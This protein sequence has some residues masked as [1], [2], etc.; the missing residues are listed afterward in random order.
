MPASPPRRVVITG[1]GLVSP[2]G[3]DPE[4]LWDAFLSQRSGVA[5]M[6]R[7]ATDYLPT[8]YGAEAWDFS[9]HIDDFGPLESPQKRTIRKGLKVMC[10]EVQMGVAAAQKAIAASSLLADCDP[11]R[12]G[13]MFGADY[14]VTM[15]DEFVEGVR[16]CLD[17][18][19]QFDFSRWAE[20]GLPRITPLWLL[21]YLPNMPASHVAIYNDLRG[22]NNSIT[23]REAS[24]NL[25]CSEAFTTI[26]RGAADAMVVG[27]TGSR[28]NPLRTVHVMIQGELATNGE[29]PAKLCRPFDL[30]RTG[31]VVG[32][33]AGAIVVEEL[34]HAQARGA[35]VLGEIVG[36][37]SSTVANR[38]SVAD[39]GKAI[40]NVLQQS[41]RTASLTPD[42]VGHINAHGLGTRAC[43]AA[44]AQAIHRLFG[45]RRVPVMAP[46]SY[47]G[48][49][50][51]GSGM[52]EL[53]AS[54][55]A[56][57]RSALFP[58][59]N[60]ETP[61]P[62]CPIQASRADDPPGD[63]FLNVNVSPQ[64]QASALAVGRFSE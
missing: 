45:D 11:D 52:I 64:G 50:G 15:P 61:D 54:L 25:A 36:Y 37:G 42:K 17:D 5:K 1:V 18:Q 23:L 28:V 24:A 47:F 8:P 2:L 62:D 7:V 10:R 21:K 19:K 38:E 29:D 40:E 46:K 14:M 31:A 6:T 20:D 55:T 13:V 58:I 57:A 16:H 12:T 43:D 63:C 4:T 26:K 59:L 30:N 3:G 48:N 32:E 22:P 35:T 44:E 41:F 56:I 9:G 39:C 33:G 27:A 60:Y 53:I 51:A 49:L 34:G